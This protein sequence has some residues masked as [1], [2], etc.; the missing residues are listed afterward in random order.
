MDLESIHKK[1]KQQQQEF[2]KAQA[3]ARRRQENRQLRSAVEQGSTTTA[4]SS[5]KITSAVKEN[6]QTLATELKNTSGNIADILSKQSADTGESLNNLLVA[7]LM[8]R[9]P[10]LIQ[11]VKD[12]TLILHNLALANDNLKNTPLNELPAINKQI[13]DALKQLND[14]EAGE[15]DYS[16]KL[17]A[18]VKAVNSINVKPTVNVP[19][20]DT[21]IDFKPLLSALSDVQTTI[22]NNKVEFPEINFQEVIGSLEDVKNTIANLSF[23]VPNYVL[24]F[25]DSNG[26]ASQVTLDGSGNLPVAGLSVPTTIRNGK[27]T[28]TTAGTRVALVGSSTS[29]A[30]VI[31][32]ALSANTGTIYVGDSSVSSSN[33]HTLSAGESVGLAI[34]DLASVYIDSSVNGEGVTFLGS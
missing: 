24:P 6:T 18:I 4:N 25:K 20:L 7:T 17:D 29:C 28:V 5:E 26:K 31:I 27:K 9:D 30:A 11:V 23:P 21:K 8:A 12:F 3:E 33:G 19:K 10:Q 15:P 34:N 16:P 2:S 1:R 32:R 13:A 22:Q 14:Q